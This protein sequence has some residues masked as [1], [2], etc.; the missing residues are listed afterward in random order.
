MFVLGSP[1]LTVIVDHKPLVKIM[2]NKSLEKIS[3]PRLLNLKEKTLTYNFKIK[4]VPGKLNNC[5]D[6]CSRFPISSSEVS[7]GTSLIEPSACMD[8]C[9]EFC[10]PA[11]CEEEDEAIE[12][13][14][15]VE[16]AI[17]AGLSVNSSPDGNVM[18]IDVRRI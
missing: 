5:A 6:A 1:N 3:N 16:A 8:F 7:S 4:H 10:S 14:N 2:S 18:L 17:I 12:I 11:T 9:E 13:E 15:C